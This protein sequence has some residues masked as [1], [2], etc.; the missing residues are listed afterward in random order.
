[1]VIFGH[2]PT[3]PWVTQTRM[4]LSF[5]PPIVLADPHTHC[6]VVVGGGGGDVVM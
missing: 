6:D 3:T 4:V 5:V 1:V 2:Y